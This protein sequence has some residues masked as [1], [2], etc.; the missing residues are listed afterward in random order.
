MYRSFL[1]VLFIALFAFATSPAQAEDW[2]YDV[3]LYGLGASLDGTTGVGPIEAEVDVGF[4]DI[5]DKLEIGGM[6]AFRAKKGRWAV[7]TDTFFVGLGAANDRVDVDVDEFVFELD[8]AYSFNDSL[9]VVFGARYFDLDAQLDFFGPL[10]LQ[11]SFGESWV[12]PV[13]G[14]RVEAPFGERWL[15]V[16]RFDIGGFGV[17]SE[18]AYN[19]VLNF[20]YRVGDSSTLVVGWRTLDVDYDDGEGL[21]RFVYDVTSSG[22]V[23][24]LA[25]RF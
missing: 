22:P 9:E 10:G 25:L 3:F 7:M 5:L 6:V 23:V 4:S 17:G 2:N 24:G 16:G 20:G 14:L 1:I 11:V 19:F 18:S 13:V 21:E 8:A 15:V 12:D